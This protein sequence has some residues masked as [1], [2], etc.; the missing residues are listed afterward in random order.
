MPYPPLNFLHPV[1]SLSPLKMAQFRQVTTEKLL[2]SLKPGQL[3]ALKVR[4]NGTVIDG[5]HR[6]MVLRERDIDIDGLPREI[7]SKEELP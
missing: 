7:I 6:I 5:H 3:G 4:P 2:E 1:E